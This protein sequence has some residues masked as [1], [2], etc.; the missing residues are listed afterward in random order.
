M[1]GPIM[2]VLLMAA[3]AASAGAA[4]WLT[5]GRAVDAGR[6]DDPIGA[7]FTVWLEHDHRAPDAA[8]PPSQGVST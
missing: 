7:I 5:F 6:F 8:S 4:R 2:I 1:I 3:L